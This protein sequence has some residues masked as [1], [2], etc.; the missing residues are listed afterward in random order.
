MKDGGKVAGQVTAGYQLSGGQV[1]A[2]TGFTGTFNPAKVMAS[3]AALGTN[4]QT[5][6]AGPHG[7]KLACYGAPGT[8]KGTVCVWV[9]T[10]TMGV[11]EFFGSD[12]PEVVTD[13]SKAAAD[14]VK[15]RSDVEVSKS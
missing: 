15:L 7:G 13:Q 2:F 5:A 1:L 12:G 10:T 9:T 6:A 11:T 14:A 4:S 3:V 8:P